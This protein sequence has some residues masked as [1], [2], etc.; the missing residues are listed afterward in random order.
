LSVNGP[1]SSEKTKT[2]E[3]LKAVNPLNAVKSRYTL[4]IK[5]PLNAV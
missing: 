2:A 5:D 4:K 3:R 1:P